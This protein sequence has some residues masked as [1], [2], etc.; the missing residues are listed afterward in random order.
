M[1]TTCAK[2][3]LESIVTRFRREASRSAGS[4]ASIELEIRLMDV[5]YATFTAIYEALL[6]GKGGDGRPVAVGAGALTQMVGAIMQVRE[7]RGEGAQPHNPPMRIREIYFEGARRAR[8]QYVR[9]EQLMLP[10]RV[11]TGG[12][13]SYIVALAAERPDSCFSSD[14]GAVI[15]TKARVSFTLKLTGAAEAA[16]ELLW[17]IDMTAVRTLS[18]CDA[19]LSLKQTVAQMFDT[20]PPMA[21]AT[22]LAALRLAADQDPAARQL[23]QYEVE[24]EFLGPPEARDLLRPA[25][26]SAAAEVILR[27]ANPEYLREAAMQAEIYRAAQHIVRAPSF[28]QRFQHE[29]GLKQLLPQALAITRADYRDIYPPRGLYLTEK[30]DGR[31]ALAVAHDGRAVIVADTLL[32]GFE[33]PPGARADDPRLAGDTILDGELVTGAD[34]AATFYAFDVIAV[35]GEGVALEGFEKRVGR[36]A[37]AVEIVRQLGLPGRAKAFT[38]LSSDRPADLARDIGGLYGAAHPYPTDGLIFTQP[39]KPYGETINYKWKPPE[40]NTIDALARRAPAGALGRAPFADRPG[41]RLHYL[42]VS[43]DPGLFD[44][45]GLQWC[46]GY[47]DLFGGR[48]RGKG[49]CRLFPVQF[50]PSDVPLAYLYQHPDA[51]PHG[52]EIDGKVVEV[53][54]AGACGAAGGGAPLV[55]WEVTRVR[56]DRRRELAG[57]CYFGNHFHTAELT[58]LNNFDPFPLEQLWEGS[59]PSDYFAQTKSGVY[60]AQTSTL[61]FVK[62]QRIN[63]LKHAGWVVDLG[64]GKGQDLGRY[65][66]A[67]VRHL[68]AVDRDRAALS[69]LVR[70]KYSFAKRGAER[71]ARGAERGATTVHVLAADAGAPFGQTLDK[72]EALG[73]AR[74]TADALVCNL[75][76]H[77]LL[78]D[79]PALRNFVALARGTV[80]AGGQVILTVLRGEA[81]HAAFAADGIAEGE[82]WDIFEGAGGAPPS[83]KFSMRR[84]YSSDTLEPAG[85]RIGV[86]LPFS[87]GRYYEEFLVNSEALSA[88]FVTSGFSL[89]A[90]TNVAAS[91]PDFEARNRALADHLTA[92]DRRWLS[93]FGELVFQ[94]DV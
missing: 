25:D 14:E 17:R 39:G 89:V 66:G 55:E 62:T 63:S 46:P 47:A 49:A 37:E 56:E 90:A 26:V 68:V 34:G 30:A 2:P 21:P 84:L 86:L 43:I 76:V 71:G 83:R 88:E 20:A 70:R 7:G 77:Y 65:L 19:G 60:H 10:F 18:G 91:I 51:S 22:F 69:E 41:H 23:Y 82:T 5:G 80:K 58:W 33:P 4:S 40:H 35:A 12:G 48:A 67:A 36:L 64:S 72:F 9:K 92:G 31:R 73:L 15:R 8:E 13:I 79:L 28:L 94:R 3:T 54:C 29:L 1:A 45:L 59:A 93:L 53:R 11:P 85:Q 81:V 87:D 42:F 27:L 52:A 38:Y 44:A 78:A 57:N 50:S 75:A 16:P 74:A 24:A 61:N 32:D 6:A